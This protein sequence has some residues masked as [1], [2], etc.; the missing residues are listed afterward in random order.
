MNR[1]QLKGRHKVNWYLD[2][3]RHVDDEFIPHHEDGRLKKPERLAPLP[4]SLKESTDP[5]KPI[6]DALLTSN[7]VELWDYI[8]NIFKTQEFQVG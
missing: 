7:F 4:D 5:S 8:S 1:H 2:S 6:P 3:F